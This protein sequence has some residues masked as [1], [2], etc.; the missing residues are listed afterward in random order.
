LRYKEREDFS[1]ESEDQRAKFA[2]G[3]EEFNVNIFAI[4]NPKA[5]LET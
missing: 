2:G 1:R 4:K 5:R 3:E